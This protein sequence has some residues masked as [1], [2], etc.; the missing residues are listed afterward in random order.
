MADGLGIETQKK[1]FGLLLWF[2]DFGGS[3]P[4]S[5]LG[6]SRV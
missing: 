4:F 2:W 5:F 3:F 1:I 6:S